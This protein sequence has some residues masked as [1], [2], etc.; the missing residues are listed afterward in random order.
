[1]PKEIEPKQIGAAAVVVDG[2]IMVSVLGGGEFGVLLPGSNGQVLKI[3]GNLPVWSTD[4]LRAP[5]R[6]EP[7][8]AEDIAGADQN[9]AD[10]LD[11]TPEA[12]TI[13]ILFLNGIKQKI[14]A[15]NVYTVTGLV[16]RWLAST[17]T[18]IDLLATDTLEMV[19]R[20][21]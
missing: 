18:A 4:A 8:A 12:G 14:G 5:Q 10:Q 7:V 15:G 6:D 9:L 17:G 21:T 19:Y 20:G 2:A 3:V 16:V 1:M 13:P 11:F